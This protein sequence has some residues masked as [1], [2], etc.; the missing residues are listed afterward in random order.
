VVVT[1]AHCLDDAVFALVYTGND[2]FGD[3]DELGN[4]PATWMHWRMT[5]QFEV[6]PKFDAATLN[7]DIGVV[8]LDRAF[9]IKPIP[10]AIR[11]I[12]RHYEGDKVEIVGFGASG[13]DDTGV[14]VDAYVKRKGKTYYQGLP[15]I[16][17]LPVNPHPGLLKPKIRAQLM[18]LEGSAPK[19]NACAGD[20]GGPALM[21]FHGHQHIVGVSSWGDDFCNDFAYYVRVHDFLPFLGKAVLKS[22]KTH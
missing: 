21:T 17:P 7:A 4:D 20:S 10:L 9:P 22:M 15:R 6:H 19:A 18:Q 3:F 1:A 8:Y 5:E 2:F 12:G 14:P 11:D 13:L 16:K